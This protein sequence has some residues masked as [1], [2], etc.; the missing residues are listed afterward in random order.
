MN[1]PKILY[2][3]GPYRPTGW[4][5]LPILRTIKIAINIW[6]ARQAAK[7][8]W[9]AG[10]IAV[11]PHMNTAFFDGLVPDYRFLDGDLKIM[12]RCDGILVLQGKSAG[13]KAEL[14]AAVKI[15]GFVIYYKSIRTDAYFTLNERG[16]GTVIES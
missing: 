7:I 4:W 9:K 1:H 12:A 5:R 10:D 11:C 3:A 2:I 6:H 16:E 8:V 13:A 15:P 14:E